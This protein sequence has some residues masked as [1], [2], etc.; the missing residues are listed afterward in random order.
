VA[1]SQGNLHFLENG[2]ALIGWGQIPAITE[3]LA[4]GTVVYHAEVHFDVETSQ[5]ENYRSFKFPWYGVSSE[6]IAVTVWEDSKVYISWN[7]DS[8]VQK[9]AVWVKDGKHWKDVKKVK[10]TGFETVVQVGRP[11][12]LFIEGINKDGRVLGRSRVLT[13]DDSESDHMFAIQS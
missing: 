11:K 1:Q 9:W 10:R 12:V 4:N 2:N 6:S 8:E 7:G 13:T 3:F 5:A